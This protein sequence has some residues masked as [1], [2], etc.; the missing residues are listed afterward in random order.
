MKIQRVM[1][2]RAYPPGVVGMESGQE[3]GTGGLDPWIRIGIGVQVVREGR[4]GAAEW[5]RK[6][7]SGIEIG[8]EWR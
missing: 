7:Q 4:T 5:I 8:F 3:K 1:G 6:N 2:R